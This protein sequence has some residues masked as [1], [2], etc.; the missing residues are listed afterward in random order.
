MEAYT[1]EAV[2]TFGM[3]APGILTG[4]PMEVTTGSL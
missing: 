2:R 4:T 3:P 1:I